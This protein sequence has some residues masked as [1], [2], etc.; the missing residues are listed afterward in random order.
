MYTP[1]RPGN[2]VNYLNHSD[3]GVYILIPTKIRQTSLEKWLV[4]ILGLLSY[5]TAL[6]RKEYVEY[7]TVLKRKEVIKDQ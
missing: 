1:E 6:K 5:V 4:A 2:H 7:V 3:F